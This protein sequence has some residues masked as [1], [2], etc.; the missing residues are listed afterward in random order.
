MVVKIGRGK[1]GK[2][3][4]VGFEAL[5]FLLSKQGKILATNWKE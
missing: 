5:T 3:V 2:K 4:W 1:G